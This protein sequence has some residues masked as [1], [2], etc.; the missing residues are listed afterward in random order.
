MGSCW[1]E[2]PSKLIHVYEWFRDERKTHLL[3]TLGDQLRRAH[4]N[5]FHS[6]REGFLKLDFN[7]DKYIQPEELGRYV[8][9]LNIP[10]EP[11]LL[12]EVT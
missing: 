2:C 10:I 9:Q 5:R 7:R 8:F 6:I 11:Y 3:K 1:P 12:Q 4:F